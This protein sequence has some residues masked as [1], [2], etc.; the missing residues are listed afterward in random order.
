MSFDHAAVTILNRAGLVRWSIRLLIGGL[1]YESDT[2]KPARSGA[3]SRFDA[4]LAIPAAALA[5]TVMASESSNCVCASF[6]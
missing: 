4:F 2:T 5:M 1:L 6:R 3:E